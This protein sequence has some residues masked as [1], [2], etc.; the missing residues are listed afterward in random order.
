MI[1]FIT[2]AIVRQQHDS[3]VTSCFL[4]HTTIKNNSDNLLVFSY[5]M[6]Y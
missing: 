1:I 6:T 3:F 4:S 5:V 2:A